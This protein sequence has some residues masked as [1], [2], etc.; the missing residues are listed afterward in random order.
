[1]HINVQLTGNITRPF[2]EPLSRLLLNLFVPSR[3]TI[4]HIIGPKDQM[5]IALGDLA[6]SNGNDD[7]QTQIMKRLWEVF[8]GIHQAVR[9]LVIEK[10]FFVIIRN[11]N[12]VVYRHH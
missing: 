8:H 11:Y 12:K 6:Q 9:G 4:L 5:Q 10:L 1:M 2:K 7:K 3:K